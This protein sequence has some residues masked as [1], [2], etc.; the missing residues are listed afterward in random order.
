MGRRRIMEEPYT[1]WLRVTEADYEI[2]ERFA[3]T[4]SAIPQD[5]SRK[6]PLAPALEEL[7][8]IAYRCIADHDAE[9]SKPARHQKALEVRRRVKSL[10]KTH[11]RKRGQRGKDIRPR[12]RRSA[13]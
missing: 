12:K 5:G 1:K 8:E 3:V 7:L 2:I 10:P 13:P 6:P 11:K 4:R 9:F